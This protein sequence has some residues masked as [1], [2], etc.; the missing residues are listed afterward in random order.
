MTN[1]RTRRHFFI[2]AKFQ[3]RYIGLILGVM[4]STV[5][6]TGYTVYVTT[7][8]MFGE[9]L[10]AVYPQGLLLDI[11]KNINIV[12]L[13]RLMFLVPF[14]VTIGLI[15]SHRIAGPLYRMKVFLQSVSSGSYDRKL[16]LRKKDELQD[17]AESLNFLVSRLDIE[18]GSREKRF[19]TLK[20]EAERLK[21]TILAEKYSRQ[22]LLREVMHFQEELDQM[23]RL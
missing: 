10:A 6:L 4:F 16:R 2:D 15:M 19:E 17:L 13:I 7:W 22:G 23:R 3:L 20:K 18:R 1:K 5:I 21:R 9:K 11:I 8:L 14:I 12:L